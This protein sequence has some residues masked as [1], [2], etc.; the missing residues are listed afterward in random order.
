M[1]QLKLCVSTLD[2]GWALT[3]G[4]GAQLSVAQGL[5]A[6]KLGSDSQSLFTSGSHTNNGPDLVV[7]ASCDHIAV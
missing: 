5:P 4:G 3:L 2:Q 7:S 1:G 6:W